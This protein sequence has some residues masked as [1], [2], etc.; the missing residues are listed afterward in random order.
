MT[1]RAEDGQQEA[2]ADAQVLTTYRYLRMALVSVLALLTAGVLLQMSAD[3]WSLLPSISDYYWTPARSVFVGSLVA[4]GVGMIVIKADNELEDI[5]LNVGGVLAPVVAFVPTPQL[6]TCTT[7]GGDRPG[8]PQST[9]DGI[10]NNMGALLVAGGFALVVFLTLAFGVRDRRPGAGNVGGWIL[11]ARVAGTVVV[12]AIFVGAWFWFENGRSSFECNAHY[13]A[14]LVLFACIV[15][16]T[17]L[18]AFSRFLEH[19][20]A[21]GLRAAVNPYSVIT[22]LMAGVIVA[23]A[24]RAGSWGYYILFIEAGVIALFLSFWVLQSAELWTRG[25]R[26]LGSPPRLAPQ[27]PD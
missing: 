16:V 1:H 24:L 26:H 9:V 19:R 17:G 21:E 5:L 12:I 27:R 3:G 11:V 10:T 4:L 22:V 25:V 8:L 13:T 18:N 20:E 15:G 2:Q 23:G 14:A 6:G 7:S